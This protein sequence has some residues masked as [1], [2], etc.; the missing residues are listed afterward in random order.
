LGGVGGQSELNI[1]F[2]DTLEALSQKKRNET[3]IYSYID[4]TEAHYV[5]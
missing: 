4:E 3:I 2:K 5:K 1:E